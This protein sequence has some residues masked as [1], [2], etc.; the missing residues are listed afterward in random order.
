MNILMHR[1]RLHLITVFNTVTFASRLRKNCACCIAI[2][3]T[4]QISLATFDLDQIVITKCVYLRIVLLV[5]SADCL[6]FY[7]YFHEVLAFPRDN[8]AANFHF[9]I[10]VRLP[11]RHLSSSSFIN[12]VAIKKCLI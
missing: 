1:A 4:I 6:I 11:Y 3:L 10:D 2:R 8:I 5:H 12:V 9:L 7:N